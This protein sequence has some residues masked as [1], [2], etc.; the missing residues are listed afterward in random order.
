MKQPQHS[1]SGVWRSLSGVWSLLE[2]TSALH[3]I[4]HDLGHEWSVEVT[5]IETKN[6][7]SVEVFECFSRFG[8]T[9]PVDPF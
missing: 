9:V 1:I 6:E 8:A 7:W 3:S 2:T 4:P 5:Q